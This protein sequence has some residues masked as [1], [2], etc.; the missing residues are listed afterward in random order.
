MDRSKLSKEELILLDKLLTVKDES[1]IDTIM[2][3]NV[4]LLDVYYYT[5]GFKNICELSYE[6]QCAIYD[7]A[8]RYYDLYTDEFF[9]NKY[10]YMR[11]DKNFMFIGLAMTEDQR[12]EFYNAFNWR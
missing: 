4:D 12:T 11:V 2:S 8:P 7:I 3:Y 5:F 1:K 9:I 10:K 6:M